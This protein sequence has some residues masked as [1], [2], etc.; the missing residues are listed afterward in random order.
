LLAIIGD[1]FQVGQELCGAVVSVRFGEDIISV[2]NRTANDK[3]TTYKIRDTIK[4]VLSLPPNVTMEYKCHDA[5]IRDQSSFRN[6]D[7]F[8]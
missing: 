7:V 4:Q 1:Q 3:N 2:W 6:T 8:S 5:S